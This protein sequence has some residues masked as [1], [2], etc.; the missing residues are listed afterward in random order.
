MPKPHGLPLAEAVQFGWRTV[1]EY[2]VFTVGTHLVSLGVP[3]IIQWGGDVALDGNGPEFAIELISFAVSATFTLGLAKIYLRFRDGEIPVFENLFDGLTQ[4]HKYIGAWIVSL[5]A[6]LM[7]L[8]LLVVP[9]IIILIRLWFVGFAIVDTRSGPLEAI[10]QS[11]EISR[12]H[13][14]DLF[15]LFFILAGLNLLGLVCLGIGVLVTVPISGLALAHIYRTLK[16]ATL[17][18]GATEIGGNLPGGGS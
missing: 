11:W 15:A 6:V 4:I 3:M 12:R 7:G 2:P 17:A 10:Q 8:C 14:T 1:R 9:G 5:V 16:P 13:T 18:S